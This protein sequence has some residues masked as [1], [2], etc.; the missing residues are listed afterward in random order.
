VPP[1]LATPKF[2]LSFA[3]ALADVSLLES[4]MMASIVD[5]LADT[6]SNNSRERM[7]QGVAPIATGFLGALAGR[8]MIGQSVINVKLGRRRPAVGSAGAGCHAGIGTP[9]SGRPL[10]EAGLALAAAGF[11]ANDDSAVVLRFDQV[12]DTLLA[13]PTC[14][15]PGLHLDR[16]VRQKAADRKNVLGDRD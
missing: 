9:L 16:V 11:S 3:A 8:T 12:P 13:A 6:H 14:V 15:E 4:M 7:S 10:E 5:D 1:N 2:I